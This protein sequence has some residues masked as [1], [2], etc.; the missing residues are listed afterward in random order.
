VR[1][2]LVAP[3]AMGREQ[4]V[5][6]HHPAHAARARDAPQILGGILILAVSGLTQ[7]FMMRTIAKI[8]GLRGA[9]GFPQ[10]MTRAY[11]VNA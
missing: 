5:L 7:N 8:V 4:A 6:S 11:P 9:A 10:W 1:L 3:D 2:L